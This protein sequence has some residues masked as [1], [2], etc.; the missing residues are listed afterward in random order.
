[1]THKCSYGLKPP[2]NMVCQGVRT[3][4]FWGAHSMGVGGKFA[5]F[6]AVQ[7]A[8]LQ[9]ASCQ[10]ASCKLTKLQAASLPKAWQAG[11]PAKACKLPS[12]KALQAASCKLKWCGAYARECNH[13]PA[14]IPDFAGIW[15]AANRSRPEI[16]NTE[17]EIA[18]FF[19][20]SL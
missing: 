15:E 6:K 18:G 9:A 16:I 20:F 3:L 12:C 5:S 10:A 13:F 4:V 7:A 19:R 14:I 2:P 17:P 1:M 11:K 8:S